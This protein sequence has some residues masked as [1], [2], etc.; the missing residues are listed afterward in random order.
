MVH[1]NIRSLYPKLDLFIAYI[2]LF[3]VTFD[4][5]GLSEVWLNETNEQLVHIPKYSMFNV[6]RRSRMGGGVSLFIRDCYQSQVLNDISFCLDH[7][8]C[9][10]VKSIYR[11][12][13]VVFGCI[14]RPPN[15]NIAAFLVSLDN[16]L[17][18]LSNVGFADVFICGDFNINLMNANCEVNNVEF[19][20]LMSAYYYAPVIT[21]PSRIDDLTGSQSLID[22]IFSKNPNNFISGILVSSISDH[23]P[24]FLISRLVY[25]ETNNSPRSVKFRSFNANAMFSIYDCLSSHDFS[26]VM[27]NQDVSR[28]FT[29]FDSVLMGYYNAFFPIKTRTIS[30]KDLSKPWI[31]REVKREIKTRE[32]Y[33]K[34]FKLGRMSRQ[35]FNIRRNRVTAMIR[36]RKS[37]YYRLKFQEV[38]SDLKRT[39]GLI[40]GIISP[41]RAVTR[42]N[43]CK[44]KLSD[45]TFIE[46][47][48]DIAD[49]LNEYFSTV[50]SNIADSFGCTE[51]HSQYMSGNYP[52]S[53]FFSPAT[54]E[55]IV[56]YVSSLKNKKCSIDSFPAFLLK[57]LS[58]VLAPVLCHLVNLSI[59]SASFP[60]FLKVARVVPLHKGGDSADMGNYR[61]VS[62]LHILSKILEK[63]VHRQLYS[64]LESRNILIDNQFGFRYRRST[65]Q[66]VLRHTEFIYGGLDDGDIVFSMYLDFKKAFD[67]VDHEIL[68]RKL[69]H[70]GVRG[71]A[72]DWFRS[73]LANR[74][75]YVNVNNVV[76]SHRSLTHSV[77]Q[78]SNLGPLLFL[79]FINDLP[80][81]TELFHFLLFADDST[82]SCR[83]PRAN[84]ED[85]V[86]L[87][88]HNLLSVGKW[89][90]CNKIKINVSKTK[91]ILYSYRGNCAFESQIRIADH[92]IE[93]TEFVKFLGVWLDNN[94]TFKHHILH[95]SSKIS[96]NIGIL[97]RLRDFVPK[98]VLRALYFTLINPYFLYALEVWFH[99]PNYLSDQMLVLQKRAIRI[100]NG[101]QYN[102]HT[103]DHFINM[104][105]LPL[106]SQFEYSVLV[107]MYRTINEPDFDHV[108]RGRLLT[109]DSVHN[110][111]TRTSSKFVI[112][113][114]TREK[115]RQSLHYAGV[116]LYNSLPDSL[117]TKELNPFKRG[118]R[119]LLLDRMVN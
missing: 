56:T 90:N 44:L 87:I 16:I 65:C 32:N 10:F 112:P 94:L 5:I 47:D 34:L 74:S 109:S 57:K 86:G 23:Y 13:T 103:R 79:V 96:K 104:R 50:G 63:H 48:V 67:T 114:I 69:H 84:L 42:K 54:A 98:F 9:I 22:N 26:S 91:Y 76:S 38:M 55:D 39:W 27:V 58:N 85:S 75:Q 64:Y 37:E 31:D 51:D 18:Y 40:N 106:T 71:L 36:R 15:A 101:L 102:D 92:I 116:V 17:V 2:S 28:A 53:F 21:K 89:L 99:A 60:D 7:I 118:V 78:G 119:E 49:A 66:A 82:V 111:P 81:C 12:K 115:S 61:P 62:V 45:D 83:L 59:T 73:Y 95:L 110:Y 29:E 46:S 107:Y 70:Y 3:D 88:N 52:D 41:S 105:L 93:Q 1:L 6:L 108:L 33:Y 117:K 24:V 8:E 25:P 14:Y 97:Y 43:I 68:L 19:L 35:D 80:N 77:P 11:R 100:V 4:A 20:N 30:Y 113:R 72:N